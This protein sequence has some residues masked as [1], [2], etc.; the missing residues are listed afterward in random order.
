MNKQRTIIYEFRAR[1]LMAEDIR[2]DVIQFLDDAAGNLVDDFIAAHAQTERV[3]AD[4]V[5]TFQEAVLARFPVRLNADDVTAREGRRG[6]ARVRARRR[7]GGLW[8]QGR[9][10]GRRKSAPARTLRLPD[11]D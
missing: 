11:H 4:D 9:D 7:A 5:R 10:R 3:T 2:A 1:L 8:P 6:A